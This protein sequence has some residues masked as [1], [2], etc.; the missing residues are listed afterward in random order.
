MAVK[1]PNLVYS[2]FVSLPLAIHP[3]LV[4]KLVNFQ[5][6]ILGNSDP[7]PDENLESDS[8]KDTSE[9]EDKDQQKGLDVAVEDEPER[10]KVDNTNIRLMHYPPKASKSSTLSGLHE[11]FFGQCLCSQ[12]SCRRRWQRGLTFTSLSSHC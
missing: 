12:C 5:N 11:R 1:S 10:V 2:H 9:D 7:N 8:N 6:S 4:D 3:E